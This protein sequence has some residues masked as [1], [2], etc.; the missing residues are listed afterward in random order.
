MDKVLHKFHKLGILTD[1]ALNEYFADVLSVDKRIKAILENV[2]LSRNANQFDRDKYKIWKEVWALPDDVIDYACTLAI[3]KDQPMQYLSSILSSFHDKN[4][5]NV[6]DAKNSFDI[7]SP[8]SANKSN[9]STGRSYTKEEMNALF[10]SI[11]DI[12]I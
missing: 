5:R 7:I 3:G 9:F 8:K 1:K 12:E 4:I 10:Q 2:G 6:E 11:D